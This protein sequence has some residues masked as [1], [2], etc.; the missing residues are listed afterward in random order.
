VLVV[1]D[2]SPLHLLAELG[3]TEI[4]A[5]LFGQVII[6]PEVADELSSPNAPASVRQLI[7][8]PPPWL[9]QSSPRARL[10][11]DKLDPGES[12]AISLAFELA[13]PL[14]IDERAGRA[15]AQAHGVVVVGAIGFLERASKRTNA[16]D[17][18][19]PLQTSDKRL[20]CRPVLSRSR[21]RLRAHSPLSE[22]MLRRFP[23]SS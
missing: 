1:S 9:S 12:A 4:L 13:V 20:N 15:A 7:A 19:P 16:G 11:L 2:S 18:V 23:T 8:T 21:S 3:Q 6:P 17:P 10:N 5:G 22:A 14:L